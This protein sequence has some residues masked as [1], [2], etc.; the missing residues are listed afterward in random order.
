MSYLEKAESV[1]PKLRS[2]VKKVLREADDF[3]DCAISESKYINGV[4]K[5]A[6]GDNVTASQLVLNSI[7]RINKKRE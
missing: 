1:D 3:R 7:E 6:K 4:L 5:E 2:S